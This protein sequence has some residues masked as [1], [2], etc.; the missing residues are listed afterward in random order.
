MI[1]KYF[2]RLEIIVNNAAVQFPQDDLVKISNARRVKFLKQRD[3]S[4][5]R[6]SCSR[7][8]I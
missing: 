7:R 4:L 6:I 5:L 3:S 8:L 2:G 1:Q